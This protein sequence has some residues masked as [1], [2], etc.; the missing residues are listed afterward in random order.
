MNFCQ[1]LN[2]F[3]HWPPQGPLWSRWGEPV[4]PKWIST[5]PGPGWWQTRVPGLP[6]TQWVRGFAVVIIFSRNDT[7]MV[8]F[9]ANAFCGYNF[10]ISGFCHYISF[11]LAHKFRGSD[12]SGISD[13]VQRLPCDSPN[14]VSKWSILKQSRKGTRRNGKAPAVPAM[15]WKITKPKWRHA[16]ARPGIT[17]HEANGVDDCN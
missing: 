1:R 15:S 4:G 5:V 14:A 7:R 9:L 3:I 12:V 13:R 6:G 8:F 2:L 11:K 17:R 10:F 16:S